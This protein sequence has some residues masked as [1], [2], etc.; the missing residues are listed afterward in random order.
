MI[1]RRALAAMLVAGLALGGAGGAAVAADRA[2]PAAGGTAAAPH[3]AGLTS[4]AAI[5]AAETAAGGRAIRFELER[6]GGVQLCEVRVVAGEQVHTVR[7]DPVTGAVRANARDGLLARLVDREDRNE[8]A[9]LLRAP[10]TLQ[11]AVEAAEA[12]SGGRALEG[13]WEEEDGSAHYEVKVLRP[14]G[15]KAKMAVDPATG[16]A[17]VL[18]SRDR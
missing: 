9:A 14:D 6:E 10:K 8:I 7:L 3:P 17:R 5:A 2:G 15:S 13:G 12:A 18:A 4:S 11:Q 1:S 16:Q